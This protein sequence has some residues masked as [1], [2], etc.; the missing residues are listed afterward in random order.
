MRKKS[1]NLQLKLNIEKRGKGDKGR[2]IVL[3]QC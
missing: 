2:K 1:R 3:I